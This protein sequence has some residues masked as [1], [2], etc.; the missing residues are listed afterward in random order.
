IEVKAR[1]VLR[2]GR[3][4]QPAIVPDGKENADL[5]FYLLDPTDATA[6]RRPPL[7]ATTIFFSRETF[8][9]ICRVSA[10]CEACGSP[11]DRAASADPGSI[12]AIGY[13]RPPRR[14]YRRENRQSGHAGPCNRPARY[15]EA[16]RQ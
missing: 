15:P 16:D 2:R 7:E 10:V 8:S 5:H 4:D 1:L 12:A 13:G 3:G 14:R 9:R 11:V 6:N